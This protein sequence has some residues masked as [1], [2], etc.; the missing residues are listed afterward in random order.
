VLQC[1][2]TCCNSLESVTRNASCYVGMLKSVALLQCVVH[3][4]SSLE[5]STSDASCLLWGGY[6]Q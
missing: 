5:F 6:G 4:R 1:V 3:C 2:G